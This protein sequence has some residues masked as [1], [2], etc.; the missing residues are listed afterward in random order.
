[1]NCHL[2]ANSQ[3]KKPQERNS[4]KLSSFN[5]PWYATKRRFS[6]KLINH[7]KSTKM[8]TIGDRIHDEREIIKLIPFLF[9]YPK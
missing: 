7:S 6:K 5:E 8:S 9:L 4:K 1:M 2:W 3:D